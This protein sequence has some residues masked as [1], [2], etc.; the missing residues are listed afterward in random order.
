M[1]SFQPDQGAIGP[2]S[3]DL[4]GVRLRFVRISCHVH[5]WKC[6][7]RRRLAA[8]SRIAS[9]RSLQATVRYQ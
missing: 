5:W 1:C 6:Q 2:R 4:H 7:G 8:P 3:L 9:T